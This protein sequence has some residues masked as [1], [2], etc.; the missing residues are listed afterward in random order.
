MKI[1]PYLFFI[2]VLLASC[3]PQSDISFNP[4]REVTQNNSEESQSNSDEPADEGSQ[5]LII[6][7]T[8][9][10]ADGNNSDAVNGKIFCIA[11]GEE[12][13]SCTAEIDDAT[14]EFACEGILVDSPVTCFLR[15]A[16]NDTTLA[17]I[18]FAEEDNV[19][20]Q[21]T[22][23]DAVTYLDYLS[24]STLAISLTGAVDLGDLTYESTNPLISTNFSNVEA[25]LNLESNSIDTSNLHDKDFE[26]TCINTGNISQYN[27]C[28]DEIECEGCNTVSD[29]I[30]LRNISATNESGNITILGLWDFK[31]N[32]TPCGSFDMNDF[33]SNNFG[34]NNISI[35][36]NTSI[37]DWSL[38]D[39]CP[40]DNWVDSTKIQPGNIA[41]FYNLSPS[42]FN[43]NF[44]SHYNKTTWEYTEQIDFGGGNIIN[45]DCIVKYISYFY[46]YK[47][48]LSNIYMYIRREKYDD[49]Q[50]ECTTSDTNSIDY[51]VQ[52][53]E[54]SD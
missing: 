22:T 11:Q 36:E 30:Y 23:N 27:N 9:P 44:L 17:T 34:N 24:R 54:R 46:V 39:H 20:I 51:F 47:N 53:S 40:Y 41:S 14:G 21:F 43:S 16:D 45:F 4:F 6:S 15:N 42:P 12:L 32:F 8:F 5:T 10:L 7:G 25:K 1:I 28:L 18:E 52:I 13:S 3:G 33:L 29:N 48:S 50:S 26:M 37:D 19:T 2:T 38:G 49:S 35:S 31:S